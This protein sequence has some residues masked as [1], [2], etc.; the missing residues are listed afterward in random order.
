MMMMMMSENSNSVVRTV[1]QILA[2]IQSLLQGCQR[3]QLLVSF[4]A[5]Q[6]TAAIE[7]SG[8]TVGP[9]HHMLKPENIDMHAHC[10]TM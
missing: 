6:T 1:E 7:S 5:F 9:N 8:L 2:N 3:R 4:L 10:S